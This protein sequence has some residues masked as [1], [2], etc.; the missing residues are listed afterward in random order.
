MIR[1]AEA[2]RSPAIIQLFPWTMAF[3][4]AAF[5]SYVVGAARASRVPIAVHLDHC[6][7]AS[8]VDAALALSPPLDSLMVD[9]SARD[10]EANIAQCA[11][12][13]RGVGPSG[14]ARLRQV[15]GSSV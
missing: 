4:G 15:V 13:V 3:Q 10:P 14:W 5:I 12:V 2:C 8:D 1:A 6:I 9:A 11:A 7:E